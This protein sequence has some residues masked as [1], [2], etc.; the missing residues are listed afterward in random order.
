MARC[1]SCG[2]EHDENAPLCRVCC[3][4]VVQ[5]NPCR[6]IKLSSNLE[7]GPGWVERPTRFERKDPL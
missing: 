6:E 4:L 7:A 2:V 3:M 5:E 1:Y